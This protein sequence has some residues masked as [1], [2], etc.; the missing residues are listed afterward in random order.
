MAKN[1]YSNFL[2]EFENNINEFKEKNRKIIL[3]C[4]KIL[5]CYIHHMTNKNINFQLIQNVRNI[6]N[7]KDFSKKLSFQDFINL[8]NY[9]IIEIN[10]NNII[11]DNDKF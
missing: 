10:N 4:S 6:L 5:D 1:L 3:L 9:L 11:Q 8:K 2:K 7:F